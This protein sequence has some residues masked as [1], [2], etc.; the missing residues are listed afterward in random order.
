MLGIWKNFDELE[1][2]L[3]LPELELLLNK[4]RERREQ[5]MRFTAGLQGVDLDEGKV[6]E[7]RAEIERRAQAR[8]AGVDENGIETMEFADIG[9]EV[10][11]ID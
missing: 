8:I 10:L 7:K 9:I 1:E 3:S 5:E 6:D 4:A 2:S 11:E